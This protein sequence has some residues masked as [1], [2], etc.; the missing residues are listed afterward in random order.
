MQ[1]V[2]DSWCSLIC[3]CTCVHTDYKYQRIVNM[4]IEFV[5]KKIVETNEQICVYSS[6]S[7]SMPSPSLSLP[8]SSLASTTSARP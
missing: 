7:K 1:L 2:V 4:Q 5:A 8:S 3:V 6:T